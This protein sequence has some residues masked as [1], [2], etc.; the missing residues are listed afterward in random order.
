MRMTA[1][2]FAIL[3]V[4]LVGVSTAAAAESRAAP[5]ERSTPQ[6]AASVLDAP[7]AIRVAM[8]T[9][10]EGTTARCFSDAF[11]ADADAVTAARI[12][13]SFADVDL[14]SPRLFD[15]GVAI[16]S[17][18]GAFAFDDDERRQL[19]AYLAAGGFVIASAGCSN[20]EWNESLAAELGTLFPAAALVTL[21]ADHDVY[22]CVYD[23]D[24]SR[25]RSGVAR[26]PEL[27]ALE[28]DGRLAMV[29]SPDGLNDT[30]ALGGECCCCGGDEVQSARRL[31]VNL[32]LYALTR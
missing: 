9:Y 13:P 15:H 14:A 2:R 4:L 1:C 3:F 22:R 27:R 7:A 18:E 31:N 17:G 11:L 30:A 29:W 8:L 10:A 20:A 24:Y 12:A 28:V 21:D 23:V 16:L 32:L 25:Y 5:G 26:L 6:A 19:G